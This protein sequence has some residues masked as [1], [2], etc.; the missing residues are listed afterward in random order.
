MVGVLSEA[1]FRCLHATAQA[2]RTGGSTEEVHPHGRRAFMWSPASPGFLGLRLPNDLGLNAGQ[3]GERSKLACPVGCRLLFGGTV[4]FCGIVEGLPSHLQG[5]GRRAGLDIVRQVHHL[6]VELPV[7]RISKPGRHAHTMSPWLNAN[8][9][10]VEQDMNV[11]AQQQP[12]GNLTATDAMYG[13]MWAASNAGAA[14]HSVI[15]Q[16]PPYAWRSA[17][18]NC[19]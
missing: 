17:A 13:R 4:S 2:E 3:A 9:V 18:R 7:Y 16:R 12:V 19:G 6:A 10:E 11:G 15:A 14:S 1:A 8:Q 5:A